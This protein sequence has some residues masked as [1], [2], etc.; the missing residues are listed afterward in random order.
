MAII[1]CLKYSS[2]KETAVF[3]IVVIIIIIGGG[4]GGID[5]LIV[6]CVRAG[7]S[8]LLCHWCV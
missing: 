1:K 5:L 4:G 6:P 7:H 8:L 2:Y 3:V